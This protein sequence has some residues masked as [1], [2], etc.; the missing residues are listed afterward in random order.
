MNIHKLN[1]FAIVIITSTMIGCKHND[2]MNGWSR[3]ELDNYPY[4]S[5]ET[6]GTSDTSPIYVVL[7]G[8]EGGFNS[9]T[10]NI[11]K[12]H[13]SKFNL[14]GT[15]LLPMMEYKNPQITET[16]IVMMRKVIDVHD[17]SGSREKFI[18]G[19]SAG[20]CL[21][22]EL[23]AKWSDVNGIVPIVA[24]A[25]KDGGGTPET[26]LPSPGMNTRIWFLNGYDSGTLSKYGIYWDGTVFV[27][28]TIRLYENVQ[29]GGNEV[30]MTLVPGISHSNGNK[31]L[32]DE[33]LTWLIG[34]WGI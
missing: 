7:P 29:R 13:L 9:K 22:L 4:Y 11:V 26:E 21:S 23:S 15:I 10:G 8:Y 30:K 28:P 31:L 5:Y 3:N 24:G 16:C 2:D 20:A 1:A 33:V 19:V 34:R 6:K 14:G 12:R 17:A 25:Y 32:T 18:L 27:D